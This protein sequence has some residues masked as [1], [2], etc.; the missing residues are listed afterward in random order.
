[1]LVPGW[2]KDGKHC[3]FPSEHPSIWQKN[4]EIFSSNFHFSDFYWKMVKFSTSFT[5]HPQIP[6]Q[7]PA[8]GWV[9]VRARC[10]TAA[11]HDVASHPRGPP[12]QL[13]SC[14]NEKS[15]LNTSEIFIGSWIVIYF[16]Q[17]F[18]NSFCISIYSNTYTY[19]NHVPIEDDFLLI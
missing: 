12:R 9:R 7:L 8:V 19:T 10:G 11:W 16:V 15:L 3:V 2:L 4:R 5:P 14:S 6:Q 18:S 17:G 1:M 13:S